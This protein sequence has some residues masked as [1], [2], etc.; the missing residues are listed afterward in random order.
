MELTKPTLDMLRNQLD[1]AQLEFEEC[2]DKIK[3]LRDVKRAVTRDWTRIYQK[4]KM[5]ERR[6][7]P[8]DISELE[9]A[10]EAYRNRCRA[11]MERHGIVD[12]KRREAV[13]VVLLTRQAI[14]ALTT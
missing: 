12:R 2:N 3:K 10:R 14:D 13:R 7:V 8:F 6:G 11:I 1:A 4:Y 5:R 9:D